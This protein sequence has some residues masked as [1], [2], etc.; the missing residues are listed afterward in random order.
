MPTTDARRRFLEQAFRCFGAQPDDTEL[1]VVDDG[2]SR[3]DWFP[4]ARVL[5]VPPGLTI[6]AKMNRGVEAAYGQIIVKWD[7]DDWYGP[8]FVG[9]MTAALDG[10][11][12]TVAAV[13]TYLTFILEDWKL[14]WSG[15]ANAFAGATLCFT[16][17][18]WKKRPFD[19]TIA[20]G[21]DLA[22]YRGLARV[23]VFPPPHNYVTIRHGSHTWR[24]WHGGS[25]EDVFR[26]RPPFDQTPE[27]FFPEGDLAFYRKIAERR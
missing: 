11:L 1:V 17:D 8:G 16:K 7:D 24:E 12:D 21:E 18:T 26:K 10:R 22:F 15:G 6:G 13:G 4:D 20:V 3:M 19:E 23:P 27:T 9:R 2:S 14:R 5:K 25:V